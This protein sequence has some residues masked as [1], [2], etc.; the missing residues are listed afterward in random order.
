MIYSLRHFMKYKNSENRFSEFSLSWK[1]LLLNLFP[2][3]INPFVIN[4]VY[5]FKRKCK[6]Y[7]KSKQSSFRILRSSRPEVFCKKDAFRNFTKFT[8]EQLRQGLFFNKVAGLRL[9]LNSFFLNRGGF[10][11]TYFIRISWNQ[12]KCNKIYIKLYFMK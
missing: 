11:F 1:T 9:F 7:V 10:L 3:L 8:G 5:K 6:H 12:I 2:C 4:G